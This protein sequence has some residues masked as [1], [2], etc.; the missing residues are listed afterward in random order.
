MNTK[1][2][3]II[4][5]KIDRYHIHPDS[6]DHTIEEG[7]HRP[8]DQEIRAILGEPT[9]PYPNNPLAWPP[10]SS[11]SAPFDRLV[12]STR[13]TRSGGNLLKK[14][15]AKVEN[16]IPVC[17]SL[18]CGANQEHEPIR[19]CTGCHT[20]LH[21]R[22]II[23]PC[24]DC[25]ALSDYRRMWKVEYVSSDTESLRIQ[26]LQ[27]FRELVE[28]SIWAIASNYPYSTFRY[29]FVTNVLEYLNRN[30]ML[31]VE[32]SH[33]LFK[34]I[35]L[36]L[37]SLELIPAPFIWNN[38]LVYEQLNS[39]RKVSFQQLRTDAQVFKPTF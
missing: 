4:E 9:W 28:N 5:V 37:P 10:R 21:E 13:C 6:A 38:I 8:V 30:E 24:V 18:T 26:I 14:W 31:R 39:V 17:E 33:R 2:D 3:N 15:I 25:S 12:R 19:R 35:K 23:G 34:E 27:I 32:D 20:L 11:R 22:C 1:T 36:A 7:V 29:K 16:N